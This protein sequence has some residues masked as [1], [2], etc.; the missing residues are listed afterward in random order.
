MAGEAEP[1]WP[2]T[3]GVSAP[4]EY[5]PHRPN[6]DLVNLA[7]VP[8]P[9]SARQNAEPAIDRGGP[10]KVVDP[11]TEMARPLADLLTPA[12]L[13]ML[14]RVTRGVSEA[15]IVIFTS[16]H[17]LLYLVDDKTA[18]AFP[19][20]AA[21]RNLQRLGNT[22][23]TTKRRDPTWVPTALQHQVYRNL[24]GAV[25]PGSP[26]NPLGT[27]ALNLGIPNIRIHGTNE[28]EFIGQNFSDGCFRMYNKDIEVLFELVS[29]GTEVV[30]LR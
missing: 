15:K 13:E 4:V 27:R 14:R 2:E 16:Q 5:E 26:D 8:A 9:A 30:I 11:I 7:A 29:V 3:S 22:R 25:P 20:G 28:D 10:D 1:P 21:R 6:S 23:I 19:I 12:D 18:V 24:P 17:R